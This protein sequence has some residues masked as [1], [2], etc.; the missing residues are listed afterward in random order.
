M[1]ERESEP[2]EVPLHGVLFRLQHGQSNVNNDWI[3]MSSGGSMASWLAQAL[4][5]VVQ[6][7]SW[8]G[9]ELESRDT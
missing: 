5:L 8:E 7:R 2:V 3:P 1:S 6:M 9:H 4:S